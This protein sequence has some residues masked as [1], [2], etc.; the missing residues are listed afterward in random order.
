MGNG[1][2]VENE[3]E[4]SLTMEKEKGHQW[5]GVPGGKRKREKPDNGKGEKPSM[6]GGTGRRMKKRKA[7][8]GKGEPAKEGNSKEPGSVK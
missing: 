5:K 7:I 3:K 1:N 4:K 2:R 6:E 8:N